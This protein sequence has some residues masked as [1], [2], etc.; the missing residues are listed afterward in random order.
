MPFI[1][2]IIDDWAGH[3]ALS[4]MDG[5]SSYNHIQIHP[6]NQYKTSFTTPWG[7]FSYRVM[8]FVLKNVDATFQWA[9]TYIF[10]DLA[11]IILTYLDNLTSRSKK[12]THHLD[13]L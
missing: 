9:M 3:E 10:H 11:K 8:P 2:Q 1:D 6:A 5:F 12:Y 13:D 4:F 7:T